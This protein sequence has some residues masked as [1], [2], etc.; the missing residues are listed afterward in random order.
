MSE[1]LSGYIKHT[2]SLISRWTCQSI[3]LAVNATG[4]LGW[5]WTILFISIDNLKGISTSL[6]IM[7]ALKLNWGHWKALELTL[8]AGTLGR[9]G[10]DAYLVRCTLKTVKNI[11]IIFYNKHQNN[12]STNI[13]SNIFFLSRYLI[14]AVVG[15]PIER[16][17]S[18]PISRRYYYGLLW[19]FD[20]LPHHR[21]LSLLL[22]IVLLLLLSI[23]CVVV[24]ASGSLA[25][26][27]TPTI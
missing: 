8:V 22:S 1:W 18:H 7:K 24:V 19:H 15:T 13:H 12:N 27:T 6:D 2:T 20:R 26:I 23:I 4:T 11:A 16:R 3:F 25:T 14:R 9:A 10:L 17:V 21:L 5:S